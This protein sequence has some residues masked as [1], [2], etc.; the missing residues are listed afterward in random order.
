MIRGKLGIQEIVF[1]VFVAL[2]VACSMFLDG[3][4]T[5]GNM[6]TLLQ[7]VALLG[8]LGLAAA[9]VVIGRGIDLSLIAA[10]AVPPGLML[11]LVD[12]GTPLPVAVAAALAM[13]VAFGAINGW[14]IAYAEVPAIFATLASGIF[15]AGF[16]QAMIF[17]LDIVPWS[18][19]MAGF[20]QLAQGRVLGI[21][22]QVLL[23]AA[24]AVAAGA[25]LRQTRYGA[26]IYA[27][28]DNPL[29][30]RLV[31]LPTRPMIVL[32]FVLAA[33]IGCFAGFIMAASVNSM[34]T[35]IFNSTL[36][37]DVILVVVLGGIGLS[38]G[39]GGAVNVVLGTLLIGTMLNA[40]TIMNLPFAA[41]NLV[42]GF[43]LLVAVAAD[44]ILNP[45]NEETAQQGDI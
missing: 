43:V 2:F 40:L 38:G 14:I 16:G 8:I 12:G 44:S 34:P 33:L 37:Y 42:K 41:Q 39:R 20:E 29:A 7:S 13:A 5:L 32:Q 24:L 36:I 28:G 4:L 1:A 27:L 30:A 21:P 23:F 19:G 25:F 45:R 10:L 35:R 6:L 17:D 22:V 3:F 9:I 18:D 26:A 15:L 11:H 31:G